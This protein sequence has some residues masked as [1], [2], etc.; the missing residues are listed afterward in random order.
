MKL[1]WYYFIKLSIKISL[2]FYTKKIRISGR[3]NIPKKGAVM[4]LVNHPNGLIDP[5]VLAVNNP[6]IQHFLVKA[7]AF[8]NPTVKKFLATLNLMPIYRIRDGV[9]ELS[10]NQEIFER[11]Y[12]IL[13]EEKALMIFPEGSHNKMRT[14]RPLSKGFT[15]IVFGALERSPDLKIHLIPVGLTYQNPSVYPG[16]VALHY[17]TSILA[18]NYYSR[19]NLTS[20][21]VRLKKDISNQLKE[22]SVHI[23]L[24]ENYSETIENLNKANVDFT[25]VSEVNSMIKTQKIKSKKSVINWI[26]MLKP[27]IVINSF[28]PWLI[29]K[30][31]DKKNNE[32]EF[33][34]TFRFSISM[35]TTFVFYSLQTFLFSY[36]WSLQIGIYY[37]LSS[38][39][40]LF[41]YAKLHTTPPISIPE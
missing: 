37:L 22:L 2:F 6:R 13:K 21:I 30:Y 11:C 34:D 40:V 7:G 25:K 9:K 16:K 39:V 38:L 15:R 3:E 20:E 31:V 32:F 10:K 35:V 27:L 4:F 19:E 18:N 29:W 17:G 41:L 33:I 26:Q 12:Q 36:F 8:K 28:F 14:I 24:D 23:P 5:L 1:L